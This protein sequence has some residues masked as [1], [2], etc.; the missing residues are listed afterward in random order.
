[1]HQCPIA[2]PTKYKVFYLRAPEILQIIEKYTLALYFVKF[3]KSKNGFWF[4]IFFWFA[5]MP[6]GLN[7]EKVSKDIKYDKAK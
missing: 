4:F 1:M 2:F 5:E 6:I 7:N 3:F